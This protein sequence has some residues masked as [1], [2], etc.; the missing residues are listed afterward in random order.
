[1]IERTMRPVIQAFLLLTFI[2]VSTH[3]A[4]ADY[5]YMSGDPRVAHEQLVLDLQAGTLNDR[6]LAPA[7]KD[8]LARL[9]SHPG[10][11]A[12]IARFGR[13]KKTCPAVVVEFS[14]GRSLT[15]RTEFESGAMDWVVTVTRRPEIV[16]NVVVVPLR[17]AGGGPPAIIAPMGPGQTMEPSAQLGCNPTF[18]RRPTDTEAANARIEYPA[19]CE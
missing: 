4:F 10:F 17:G 11:I 5:R 18:R 19:M 13:L 6:N 15:L 3:Q 1:M 8:T 16:Q 12:D 9:S 14:N 7:A 2:P